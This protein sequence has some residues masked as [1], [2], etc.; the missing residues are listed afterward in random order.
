MLGTASSYLCFSE[1][2]TEHSSAIKVTVPLGCKDFKK[3]TFIATYYSNIKINIPASFYRVCISFLWSVPMLQ[4]LRVD[5]HIYK[6]ECNNVCQRIKN[7]CSLYTVQSL[8]RTQTCGVKW[9]DYTERTENHSCLTVVCFCATCYINI[10]ETIR[11]DFKQP[12][13]LL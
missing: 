12:L 5:K 6:I 3:A 4:Y 13:N 7:N 10:S 11:L 2:L 8:R 1:H 9:W